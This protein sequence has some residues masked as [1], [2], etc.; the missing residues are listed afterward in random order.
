MGPD[1]A[2]GGGERARGKG[3]QMVT[4]YSGCRSVAWGGVALGLAAV[5][6]VLC[7][8][9]I[10]WA[11]EGRQLAKP[12]GRTPI[13]STP[14]DPASLRD[15]K[16]IYGAD[17]RLDVYEATI[18]QQQLA[19]SVC[20]LLDSYQLTNN[21]NG[22]YTIA[23][24]AYEI[25]GYPP[26]P[27][28]P[29]GDQPTAAWCTGFLVGD[30]L[31][32]TAGHCCDSSDVATVRF[33]FGFVM[34][35]ATTPVTTVDADQVYEGVAVVGHA[36]AGDYDYSVVQVDRVVTAPGAVP[37]DI[38]RS[39]T[40]ANGTQIGVIGHPS[41]LPLKVAFG[42]LTV[43]MDNSPA[44]YF[45][46]NLDTYGGNSGSPVF[47]AATGVVE[48]ILVR[49][50]YDFDLVGACFVSH[51]LLN[52][53]G[54]EEV[55][56]ATTFAEYVP[57]PPSSAGTITLDK[58][59]YL[60]SDTLGVVV[61]DSDLSGNV[62]V[63]VTTDGGDSE[64][65][66]LTETGSGTG[67]FTG[68]I[69]VNTSAVVTENGAV[70]VAEGQ[71]ITAT[72]N[73]ADNGTGPAVVTDTASVTCTAPDYFTEW[74]DL[75]APDLDGKKVT[76]SPDGSINSYRA[77]TDPASAFPTDP[78]G[79][80]LLVL[81]DDAFAQVTLA[82]GAHVSLYG[83]SYS[84]FY[85]G[86]NGYITFGAGDDEYLESLATHF[87]LPRISPLFTDLGADLWG[88]ISWKQFTDRAVVTFENV[89]DYWGDF[90]NNF[91]VEMFFNG[92]ITVTHLGVELPWGLVGLSEGLG[93]PGDFEASD[94][95]DYPSCDGDG[96]GLSDDE[97]AIWGTD[98][99]NPDT[100][101]DGLSDG[102]EVR[103]GTNPLATEWVATETYTSADVPKPILD[104][105]TV[106]STIE[107]PGMK[108]VTCIWDVEVTLDIT[109]SYDSDLSVFLES[110][111]GTM[112]ELFT[113]VGGGGE[114]FT[115]TTLDDEAGT[116]I[117]AGS[118]P[119]TGRFQ[120]MGMLS[121]FDLEAPSGTWTLYI[122]DMWSF[123]EGTLNSWSLTIRGQPELPAAGIV[124]L[125]LLAAMLAAGGTYV[126]R[127]RK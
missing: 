93:I 112:V 81:D 45:V 89:P 103:Q 1:V 83:T 80:T 90:N 122:E 12:F 120:P 29:F 97:E 73:D 96:D 57:E 48:G 18:A 28:E 38:R 66:T 85:V 76:F 58:T 53:Q 20:A 62:D 117:T 31:I 104:L 92:R 26:C 36:L 82:G 25:E 68:S 115:D 50:E 75:Y 23:T 78:A 113:G 9:P 60:C 127:R 54:A 118:A 64:T 30:N 41:G 106:T 95:S 69:P 114:N 52:S 33:V 107:V 61:G 15:A 10:A 39:G 43:V 11:E 116:P 63:T 99:D 124:G 17:D 19:Q 98:P 42:N 123:D 34:E 37:L 74:F 84:S 109:H 79:G 44:G 16:V 49:G 70:N 86:S 126:T 5:L 101:G 111:L 24:S 71:T 105:D 87:D 59:R 102:E 65:V 2:R 119:F 67:R 32:A 88:A 13:S 91:Q 94:L 108:A 56:K 51:E 8:S 21:G 35:D 55:S 22:T 77:C 125:S 47:N 3:T 46:A 14:W 110:P 6:A 7:A 4:L 100:D 27:A 40:V 72:Y 121:D